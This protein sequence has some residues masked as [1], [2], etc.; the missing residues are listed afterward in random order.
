MANVSLRRAAQPSRSDC[1]RRAIDLRALDRRVRLDDHCQRQSGDEDADRAALHLHQIQRGRFRGR[2]R[3]RRRAGGALD[4]DLLA[5]TVY[6]EEIGEVSGSGEWG[7]GS[8]ELTVKNAPT[9]HSPFPTPHETK[10]GT[11]WLEKW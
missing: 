6:E 1:H 5:D 8:G 4:R 2:E 10:R 3:D 9:P 7:M 11:K